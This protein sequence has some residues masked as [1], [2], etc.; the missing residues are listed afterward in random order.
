MVYE[1]WYLNGQL[2]E[3][4]NYKNGKINGSCQFWYLDGECDE[5]NY[6]NGEEILS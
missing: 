3:K 5:R 1:S 6:K 4:T 2:S